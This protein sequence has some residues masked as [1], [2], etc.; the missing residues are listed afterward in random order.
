MKMLLTQE[1]ASTGSFPEHHRN[2]TG[3]KR[4]LE[5]EIQMT[6]K[7][8]EH[9][10]D[11]CL[12]NPCSFDSSTRCEISKLAEELGRTVRDTLGVMAETIE[13]V[14]QARHDVVDKLRNLSSGKVACNAYLRNS[15]L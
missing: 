2:A 6:N 13:R 7:A 12:A 4:M 11:V 3:E 8:I 5:R 1:S 9:Y 15:V 14:K 10:Y